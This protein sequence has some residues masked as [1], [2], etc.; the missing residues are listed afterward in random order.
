MEEWEILGELAAPPVINFGCLNDNTIA[1]RDR[2]REPRI[3]IE[4]KT[5]FGTCVS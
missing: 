4:V 3:G 2:D 1:F 5:T